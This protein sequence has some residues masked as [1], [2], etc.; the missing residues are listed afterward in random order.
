MTETE[1]NTCAD[2]PGML[3]AMF[4]GLPREPVPGGSGLRVLVS[5]RK[6]TLLA[7]ALGRCLQWVYEHDWHRLA[8][9]ATEERADDAGREQEIK[10]S[11]SQLYEELKRPRHPQNPYLDRVVRGVAL[12]YSLWESTE[13][14]MLDCARALRTAWGNRKPPVPAQ[15]ELLRDIFGNPFRPVAFSEPW[16]TDTAVSLA[17]QMYES[18][19]FSA[20]PILAN[21]LQDAGC[22]SA[23]I[24]DHCR[25]CG[26]HGR[27][28]WVV[29]LVLGRG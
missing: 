13:A 21:A 10:R 18:R 15:A 12:P 5:E 26:P 29:D 16:R 4:A 22:S 11:L 19:D 20:M 6:M 28:C 27:G 2:A 7:V 8:L 9:D 24:L 3:R 14:L 23:E 25:G 1:W 17:R